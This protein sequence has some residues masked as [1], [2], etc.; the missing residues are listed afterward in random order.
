MQAA[1]IHSPQTLAELESHLR[2]AMEERTKSGLNEPAAFEAAVGDLGNGHLL[3]REFACSG[4][5]W[6]WLGEDQVTRINRQLGLAWVVLSL[7]CLC[8][9]LLVCHERFFQDAAKP[10]AGL[11]ILVIAIIFVQELGGII[12]GI[13]LLRGAS[14]GRR[15]IWTVALLALIPDTVALFRSPA[16]PAATGFILAHV[17]FYLVTLCWLR[18]GRMARVAAN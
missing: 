2:D 5:F 7:W 13:L 12:G 6:G 9:T 8:N 16:Q 17:F 11:L 14:W 10:A 1:G 3:K 4:G 18:P 15:L